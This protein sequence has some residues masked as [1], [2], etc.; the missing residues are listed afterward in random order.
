MFC[1]VSFHLLMGL[2]LGLM[3]VRVCECL[4]FW[5]CD[6]FAVCERLKWELNLEKAIEFWNERKITLKFKWDNLVHGFVVAIVAAKNVCQIKI[7]HKLYAY[8]RQEFSNCWDIM[9]IWL[10]MRQ[11]C[12]H[13]HTRAHTW[14]S[15]QHIEQPICLEFSILYRLPN[16]HSNCKRLNDC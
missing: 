6:D 10:M 14:Q 9:C 3:C 8:L 7:A 11:L 1:F 4:Y 2:M 15:F 16:S 13:T 12:Q 5:S